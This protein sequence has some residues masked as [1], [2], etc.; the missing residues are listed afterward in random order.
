VLG[1]LIAPQPGDRILE[2]AAAPGGKTAQ[3]A[4]RMR[5]RGSIVAVDNDRER[6]QRWRANISRLGIT[7]AHPLLAEAQALPLHARFDLVLIDA[8]CSSLGVVRRHPEI[9]WWR[10]ESDLARLSAVQ[11]Q[12]LDA[13]AKYVEEHAE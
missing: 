10:Q 6:M 8:P 11:L 7:C 3:M 5:D 9:K 13:C 4:I 2:I 12:I 1:R